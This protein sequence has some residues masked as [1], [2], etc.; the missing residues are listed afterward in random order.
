MKKKNPKQEQGNKE[1]K[2]N[3]NTTGCPRK[4]LFQQKIFYTPTINSQAIYLIHI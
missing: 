2:G 3:T 4:V 1:R